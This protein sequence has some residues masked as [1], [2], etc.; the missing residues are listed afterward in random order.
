MHPSDNGTYKHVDWALFAPVTCRDEPQARLCFDSGRKPEV[1]TLFSRRL[2][3]KRIRLT[4]NLESAF[5]GVSWII[6]LLLAI[7]SLPIR[8]Q[9]IQNVVTYAKINYIV[10]LDKRYLN[11]FGYQSC[12]YEEQITPQYVR[13]PTTILR[14]CCEQRQGLF[15]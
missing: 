4:Q 11:M 2:T 15:Y 10:D 7:Y 5:V 12:G 9:P 14:S 13:Q 8:Y 6:Y 3:F 1:R